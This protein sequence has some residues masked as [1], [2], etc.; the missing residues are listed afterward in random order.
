MDSEFE[1]IRIHA[2]Y[3]KSCP[4]WTRSCTFVPNTN[5]PQFFA[6]KARIRSHWPVDAYYCHSI[7][8]LPGVLVKWTSRVYMLCIIKTCLFQNIS[9]VSILEPDPNHVPHTS[10]TYIIHQHSISSTRMD[11]SNSAAPSKVSSNVL[12]PL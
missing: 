10:S 9:P 8:R 11:P 6:S 12:S 3:L 1:F 5:L 4:R 2:H 7:G